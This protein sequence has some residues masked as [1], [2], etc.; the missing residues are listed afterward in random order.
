MSCSSCSPSGGIA[1]ALADL[2]I[3]DTCTCMS[4]LQY[5]RNNNYAGFVGPAG[6][7]NV[8]LWAYDHM[9]SGRAL[10]YPRL[11]MFLCGDLWTEL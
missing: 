2:I 5:T 1:G 8:P 10:V 11:I 7:H 4:T 3:H 9:H 6:V